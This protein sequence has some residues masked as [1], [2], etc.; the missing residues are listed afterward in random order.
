MK[1]EF[2]LANYIGLPNKALGGG[3]GIWE[4]WE[5]V[6]YFEAKG[7]K[8]FYGALGEGKYGKNIGCKRLKR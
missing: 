5:N 3:R 4:I 7:K 8:C 1:F 6:V 2:D